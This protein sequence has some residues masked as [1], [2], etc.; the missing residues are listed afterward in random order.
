VYKLLIADDEALEREGLEMMIRRMLPDQFEFYHAENGR[1]AIQLAEEKRPDFIFMDIKMPGIQGLEAI[2]EIKKRQ[3]DVRIVLVTAHDFFAY[4]QEAISLGVRNYILK[5]AKRDELLEVLSKLTAEYQEEKR[6]R[7]E[8]L[9][10]REK[11]SRLLPLVENEVTL[12]LMTDCIQEMDLM[13]LTELISLRW[14]RGYAMVLA[15]SYKELQSWDQFQALR[16]DLY[17][18]FRQYAKSQLHCM[19]SPMIGSKV[20]VMIPS[21]SQAAG[22]TQR[23]ES[24]Q[25]GER[26]QTFVENRY[27]ITPVVGI[28]PVR[29]GIEGLRLSY[30]AASASA[31]DPSSIVGVRHADDMRHY[32]GSPG[33][34]LEDEKRLLDVLQRQNKEEA[35]HLFSR[36][37]EQLFATASSDVIRCRNELLALLISIARR[38]GIR[39]TVEWISPI[40]DAGGVEALRHAAWD[41]FEKLLDDMSMERERRQSHVFERAKDYIRQRY[42]S[43]MSMEQTA[44]HVNLSPYYFS[45]CFK[46]HTGETFMDYLTRLRIEDAKRLLE[47][48]E[49]SFKEICYEVG[50]NDPNYFSRIFKKTT[51]LTP[52]E[53]RQQSNVSGPC[54]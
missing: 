37:L 16:K 54:P 5:P 24:L 34:S 14:E 21:A 36:M 49:L 23:V 26:F 33:I 42:K 6:K 18:G 22:L 1:K 27:G 52:T 38:L 32:S 4:A 10:L 41:P 2:R 51:G 43:D 35:R 53:Y 20:A 50:Y 15:F 3:P 11:L 45:K 28:G 29:E 48:D 47:N 30:Q 39:T 31:A 40:A 9:E 25:W 19:V 7:E 13:H 8:D 12:M 44:E 17:E 46:L